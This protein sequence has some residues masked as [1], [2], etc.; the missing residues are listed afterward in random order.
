M[1]AAIQYAQSGH[2][3]MATLHANNSYHALNRI[4]S[5]YPL[6][7]R[8]A[9]LEDLSATLRCIISQRLIRNKQGLRN[10]AVEVLL[11]TRHISEL[12]GKGEISEIKEAMEKSLSPG[13]QTFEQCLFNMILSGKI[14]QDEALANADS[15]TNLLWLI[16]NTEA[17]GAIRQARDKDPQHAKDQAARQASG[18]DGGASFSEFKL[19]TGEVEAHH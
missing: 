7:N 17:G 13:S 10:A 5:F 1:T 11:A 18:G 15:A 8:P 16:N 4:I 3:C 12:I 9:L 6:E 2:I 14:S 19:D